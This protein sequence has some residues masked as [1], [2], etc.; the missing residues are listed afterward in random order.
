MWKFS[1]NFDS[2]NNLKCTEYI[3]N[4]TSV[5]RKE[6][7]KKVKRESESVFKRPN[8]FYNVSENAEILLFRYLQFI[9]NQQFSANSNIV[10]Y[11]MYR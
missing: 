3:F 1:L 4:L 9:L 2:K 11:C 10:L 6:L 5:V 7:K 8:K